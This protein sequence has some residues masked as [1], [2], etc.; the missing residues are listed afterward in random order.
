[1]LTLIVTQNLT[2]NLILKNIEIL[3]D[4]NDVLAI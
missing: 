3:I 1:M 2:G 4:I